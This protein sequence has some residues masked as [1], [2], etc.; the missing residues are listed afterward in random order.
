M[1]KTHEYVAPWVLQGLAAFP[2]START[3]ALPPPAGLPAGSEK[4]PPLL[5]PMDKH[6]E[7]RNVKGLS[8]AARY[9]YFFT[10]NGSASEQLGA[11]RDVLAWLKAEAEGHYG[12]ETNCPEPHRSFYY[13]IVLLMRQVAV[14]LRHVQIAAECALWLGAER[15]MLEALDGP[16]GVW[17]ACF[18]ADPKSAINFDQATWMLE[19]MRGK[20]KLRPRLPAE[21]AMAALGPAHWVPAGAPLKLGT[22]IRVR[23]WPGKLKTTE[24]DQAQLSV[25]PFPVVWTSL[26]LTTSPAAGERRS[27]GRPGGAPVPVGDGTPQETVL[28]GAWRS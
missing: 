19:Y 26:D 12:P 13:Q 17:G 5:V 8:A 25:A 16:G 1:A 4:Q 21:V 24:L 9:W 3:R 27:V 6:G 28:G 10:H 2:L 11:E 20:L 15:T 14:R 22:P 7:T 23:L 18:R